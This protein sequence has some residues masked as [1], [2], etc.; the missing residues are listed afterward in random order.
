M[1]SGHCGLKVNEICGDF[2]KLRKVQAPKLLS[3][4]RI[5]KDVIINEIV[6]IVLKELF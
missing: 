2:T 5:Y 4:F 3:D 6:T 1:E